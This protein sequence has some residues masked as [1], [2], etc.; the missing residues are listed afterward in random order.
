MKKFCKSLAEHAKKI[1]NFKDK[2]E[3]IK[4]QTKGIKWK[5]K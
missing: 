4:T 2:I 3:V 5:C 1:A